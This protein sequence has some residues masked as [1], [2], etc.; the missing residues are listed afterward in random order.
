MYAYNSHCGIYMYTLYM[1][2]HFAGQ[3]G[4]RFFTFVV[5]QRAFCHF[6]AVSQSENKRYTSDFL[7]GISIVTAQR[8][9]PVLRVS[10]CSVKGND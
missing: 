6:S 5:T 10:A 1:Y 7:P 4:F 9:A 2:I 3:A 8:S